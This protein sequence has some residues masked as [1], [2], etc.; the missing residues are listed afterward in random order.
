MQLI[1]ASSSP[2]RRE[3][4]ARAG[5]TF[6][7]RPSAVIE[8]LV[9]G[10]EPEEFARR[11][12]RDKAISVA[13]GAPSGSLVLG[14]DTIV[15]AGGEVL[16]KPMDSAD[17]ARMLQLLS[18]STHQVITGVCLVRSPGEI[19][20]LAHETTLVTFRA[21]DDSEIAGYVSSGEPL[22]KA[23]AYGIQGLASRFVTRVEG[24]Y[25]NVVGLPV[26]LVYELLKPF[27]NRQR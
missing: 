7:V 9:P 16:G 17:A 13:A 27:L 23:G 21:L 1:L 3:L 24:C 4:L 6:E 14:A 8:R 5:F 10:E 15:V 25:F 12:A 2:R 18:G 26:A 11:A 20:G 22:D 19:A